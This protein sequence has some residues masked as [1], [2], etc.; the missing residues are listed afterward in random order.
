MIKL[1]PE[2]Q[3]ICESPGAFDLLGKLVKV[4]SEPIQLEVFAELIP[5]SKWELDEALPEFSLQIGTISAPCPSLS[6]TQESYY[7]RVSQDGVYAHGSDASGLYYAVQTLAQLQ[8]CFGVSTGQPPHSSSGA[9]ASTP[10]S[11]P[12]CE[13]TDSPNFPLRIYHDDIS[14]GQVST[15]EDFKRILRIISSY[16]IN[17]Y[18]PYIED[19]LY[20]SCFPDIGEGR[21]RLTHEEVR[22]IHV[23]A[24]RHNLR[25]IPAFCLLG[26]CENM[27][28]MPQYS[29]LAR[30]VPFLPSSFDVNNPELKPF[31]S[32]VI[33]EVANLFEDE[34]IHGGFDEVRGLSCEE[35]CSHVEWV[36]C[37]L[38]KYGKRLII[39]YDMF[40]NHFGHEAAEKLSG[41]VV[42]ANWNYGALNDF[43]AEKELASSKHDHFCWSGLNNSCQ[44]TFNLEAAR[45][46]IRN[47]LKQG[48]KCGA[49]AAALT[50]W[51]NNGYENQR[52]INW[53]LVA[54]F[55]DQAW[56]GNG[57]NFKDFLMRF[58]NDFYGAPFPELADVLLKISDPQFAGISG[59]KLWR[60]TLWGMERITEINPELVKICRKMEPDLQQWEKV[61]D[62]TQNQALREKAHIDHYRLCLKRVANTVSRVL[63]AEKSCELRKKGADGSDPNWR[64]SL[65]AICRDE[66]I[67]LDELGCFYRNLWL[68]HNKPENLER[69]YSWYEKLAD[70]YQNPAPEDKGN[71]QILNLADYYN[72]SPLEI[73]GIPK[74][75]IVYDNILFHISEFGDF[76]IAIKPGQE[77][78]VPLSESTKINDLHLLLAGS[79]IP[80]EDTPV[81]QIDVLNN[82]NI[83]FQETL[84]AR[85]HVPDWYAPR[86]D[87]WAGSGNLF[88]DSERVKMIWDGAGLTPGRAPL[89]G[90]FK[91][92][93]FKIKENGI[94]DQITIRNIT[95]EAT[96]H[97]VAITSTSDIDASLLMTSISR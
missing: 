6:S 45:T 37:E 49:T 5:G 48:K 73:C 93:N 41:D 46:N 21:G 38:R 26:H 91:L 2:V 78:T 10:T 64:E 44:L 69:S 16:K 51:G 94:V 55:A 61:L 27:L 20:L 39:Y 47:F 88:L 40:I 15:L 29:H 22:E 58:H 56:S 54:Y 34:F 4:H 92:D 3:E 81:M 31:L 50:G 74:G 11:V 82:N 75:Q 24:K 63:A 53:N 35:F 1:I 83:L 90:L 19:M 33:A 30:K 72:E 13:I 18:I 43:P 14:R 95:K 84:L 71:G 85:K 36:A 97:I 79:N 52:D 76:S 57:T 80:N 23:E 62:D 28:A 7:L 25:V 89:F 68:R 17:A 65:S 59:W 86:G 66:K 60:A 32:K 87:M 96:M 9:S 70:D 8:A 12:C 67:K 42:F 77:I